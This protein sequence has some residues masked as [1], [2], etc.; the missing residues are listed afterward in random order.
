MFEDEPPSKRA[1][2][3][4]KPTNGPDEDYGNIQ[5]GNPQEIEEETKSSFLQPLKI[6]SEEREALQRGPQGTG[7]WMA[8]RTSA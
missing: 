8:E 5:L 6:T 4:M 7:I 2:R 3:Y 1:K